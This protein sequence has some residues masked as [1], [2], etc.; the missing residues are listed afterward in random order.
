MFADTIFWHLLFA[1]LLSDYPLQSEWL[2]ENKRSPWGI[3]LHVSIHFVVM[4]ILVGPAREAI[5]PK[6]ILLTGVHFLLDFGKGALAGRWPKRA[7]AQ[8]AIDQLLHIISIFIVSYWIDHSLN[9]NLMP[10]NQIWPIY[11]NA[12]LIATYVWFIT[13]RIM[14][15]GDV[16]Y[17]REVEAQF[18]SRMLARAAMLTAFLFVGRR[19]ETA[20]MGMTLL[21]PY[22]LGKQRKRAF[23]ID[24]LVALV[25]AI[26]TLVAV[27]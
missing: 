24:L 10:V 3:G 27:R 19:I 2:I 15:T 20:T 22:L 8:Y 6:L 14:Y 4:F 5:W 12:Y 25:V 16:A 13:E 9:P 17:L 7:I 1:H 11:A 18:W 26:V 21:L 23:I